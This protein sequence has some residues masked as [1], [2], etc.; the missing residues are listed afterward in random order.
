MR[1]ARHLV[2]ATL[3]AAAWTVPTSVPAQADSRTDCY[4]IFNYNYQVLVSQGWT[5]EKALAEALLY[6]EECQHIHENPATDHP[7]D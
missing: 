6:Y 1:H 5:P 7:T 2:I 3:V 4:Q